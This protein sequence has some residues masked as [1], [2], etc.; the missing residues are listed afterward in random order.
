MSFHWDFW[1]RY[2][3]QKRVETKQ[4]LKAEKAIGLTN[5]KMTLYL[6][7]PFQSFCP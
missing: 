4:R 2:A 1:F 3:T 6:H 5:Q 7:I